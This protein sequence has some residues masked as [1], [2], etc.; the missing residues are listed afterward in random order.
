MSIII[1][2]I[3]YRYSIKYQGFPIDLPCMV[4]LYKCDSTRKKYEIIIDNHSYRP[5]WNLLYREY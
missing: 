5:D 4:S 2:L 3:E 1:F